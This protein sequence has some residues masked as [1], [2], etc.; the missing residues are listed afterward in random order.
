MLILFMLVACPGD[1]ADD[2]GLDP[3]VFG[4]TI[5]SHADGDQVL[6][7]YRIGLAGQVQ[8]PDGTDSDVAVTWRVDG[9]EA[10]PETTAQS[11]GTTA[12]DVELDSGERLVEL[13]AR[14]PDGETASAEITLDV[15]ETQPPTASITEPVDGSLVTNDPGVTLIGV[16]DD[17]EDPATSL[18]AWWTSDVQGDLIGVDYPQE[19]GSFAAAVVLDTGPH[20]LTLEVLD[21]TG[22]TGSDTV[23]I[24]VRP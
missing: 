19:D 4:A 15:R 9:V 21:T 14:A 2:S 6:E 1:D 18:L 10:C 20:V 23:S 24:T 17:A 12:C 7:G 3:T 8:D 11:D 22:K 13:E 5:T 16:L